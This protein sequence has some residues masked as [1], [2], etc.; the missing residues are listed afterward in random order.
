MKMRYISKIITDPEVVEK[1]SMALEED[2]MATP[3]ETE[4]NN[5]H[6]VWGKDKHH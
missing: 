4:N 3:V 6:N 5:P 1:H 2:L